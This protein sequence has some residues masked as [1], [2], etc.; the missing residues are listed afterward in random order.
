[1]FTI[2]LVLRTP[3]SLFFPA[4]LN[5]VLTIFKVVTTVEASYFGSYHNKKEEARKA[6]LLKTSPDHADLVMVSLGARLSLSL[7]ITAIVSHL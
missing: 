7:S 3:C 6:L 5:S 2:F 4:L 1:M